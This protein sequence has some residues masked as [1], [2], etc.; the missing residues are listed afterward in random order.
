[1]RKF[2]YL[3]FLHFSLLGVIF[4][5]FSFSYFS[6]QSQLTSFLFEDIIDAIARHFNIYIANSEISSD[7]TT[8]YLLVLLLF[9][10]ALFF[11]FIIVRVS[12]WKRNQK[13]MVQ[14]IQMVLVYYLS[15]IILR[16]GFDKIFMIQFYLPEPNTLYTP[17]GILDKDILYWST[18]GSSKAYNL[19]LGISEVLVAIFLLIKQTRAFGLLLLSSILLNVVL[20]NLGFDIS[21]KLYSSFLFLICLTLLAPAFT[22]LFQFLI[23]NKSVQLKII[24]GQNL[25]R[26]KILKLSLKVLLLLF[27]FAESL[28]PHIQSTE[29]QHEISQN[30]LH[31]AYEILK[32]T[33]GQKA[34][35]TMTLKPKRLFIHKNNYLIFQYE[36]DAM[37]DFYFEINIDK[38]EFILH[39]YDGQTSEIRYEYDESSKI[40]TLH[41]VEKDLIIEAKALLWKEL[42]LLQPLFHWSVDEIE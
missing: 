35:I 42:P 17:L 40:L 26:S 20:V 7:S 4:I 32:L 11:T 16:Y 12:F 29:N 36:N 41:F 24:T 3:V 2:V 25:F 23:L 9:F 34:E 21:V 30:K 5:P 31:G 18:M 37:Q 15:V 14:W 10:I 22:S 1:M 8:M 6:F 33:D 28:L 27:I 38:R 39:D 13:Q 19:F